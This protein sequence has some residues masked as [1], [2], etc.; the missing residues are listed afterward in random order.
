VCQL[1]LRFSDSRLDT[2]GVVDHIIHLFRDYPDLIRKFN[3]FLPPGYHI[4]VIDQV[5][6]LE[7]RVT[8]PNESKTIVQHHSTLRAVG[9]TPDAS[10][11][12]EA[13]GTRVHRR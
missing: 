3:I 9:S 8:Q 13:Q 5:D 11:E 4:G 7:I 1:L 10:I 6:S 2:L 12:L